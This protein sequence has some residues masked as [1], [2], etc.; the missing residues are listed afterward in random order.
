MQIAVPNPQKVRKVGNSLV[1]TIPADLAEQHDIKADDLVRL[2]LE[3]VEQ[4][5]IP[6][7]PTDVQA[8]LDQVLEHDQAALRY[9]GGMASPAEGSP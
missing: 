7:L 6:R 1:I 5:T 4:I 2:I 8:A 9:L 3:P